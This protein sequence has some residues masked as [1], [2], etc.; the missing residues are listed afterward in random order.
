MKDRKNI[1]VV[2]HSEPH[3]HTNKPIPYVNPSI[4]SPNYRPPKLI[5]VKSLTLTTLRQSQM[6]CV[7]IFQQNLRI[8]ANQLH[9]HPEAEG[10]RPSAVLSPPAD[11]GRRRPCGCGRI[12]RGRGD[13][14]TGCLTRRSVARA[15]PERREYS[16]TS[17]DNICSVSSE[18]ATDN[19]LH[20]YTTTNNEQ[21]KSSRTLKHILL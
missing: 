9:P 19:R 14:R 11:P 4:K 6:R 13:G 15:A 21:Q 2:R 7:I 3:Q 16:N 10:C 17:L 20:F 18:T 12:G 5:A 1:V 8:S